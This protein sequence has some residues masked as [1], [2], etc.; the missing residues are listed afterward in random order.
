MVHATVLV[1]LN[2]V[3]TVSSVLLLV[4]PWREYRRMI[5]AKSTGSQS[6]LPLIMLF[7]NCFLWTIYGFLIDSIFPVMVVNGF[8]C[9]TCTFFSAIFYR[10]TTGRTM[11]NKI[12]AVVG[13]FL[14]GMLAYT[15]LGIRG[16]THQRDSQVQKVLGFVA[17]AVNIAVYAAPLD[18]I[19]TVLATRSAASMPASLCIMNVINGS[20]WVTFGAVI[21]DMFMLTP[22]VIGVALSAVQVALIIK[23]RPNQQGRQTQQLPVTVP[24]DQVATSKVEFSLV[25]SPQ[26]Q[27]SVDKGDGGAR[28]P[29]YVSITS[30][31]EP[32]RA[33]TLDKE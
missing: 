31:M 25:L 32:P 9:F 3:T 1:V 20:L 10:Y 21:G 33:F 29:E 16:V 14:L 8:G 5:T 19:K 28:S 24:L 15:I 4:S 22:N 23:F 11:L 6:L 27:S 17:V 2:V 18:T 26:A 30:P 13:V 7:S 12:F